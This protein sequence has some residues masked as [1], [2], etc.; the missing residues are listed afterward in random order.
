MAIDCGNASLKARVLI[1][2]G[3]LLEAEHYLQS[4]GITPDGRIAYPRQGEYFSLALLLKSK[5]EQED[6]E[7]LLERFLTWAEAEKQ[8]RWAIAAWILQSLIGQEKDDP[9]MALH[10][11][12]LAMDLAEPEGFVQVFLDEGEPMAKLLGVAIQQGIRP[13]FASR[14]LDAF[15]DAVRHGPSFSDIEEQKSIPVAPEAQHPKDVR[16]VPLSEREMEVLRL[17][18][19]GCSNKE[20]AQ[21][22]SISLRTVKY[23]TTSIYTK[24]QVNGRAQ[25]AV[26]ARELG[27]LI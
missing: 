13:Q 11:L 2:L 10:S 26:K 22:L 12:Q 27:L 9:Q 23:H 4:R 16:M 5:G 20:I 8:H 3:R 15:Q 25:A 7:A 1:R 18:T 19:E 17:I 6:A 14:L 21:K 24:L